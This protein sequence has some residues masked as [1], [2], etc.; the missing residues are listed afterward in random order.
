MQDPDCD[1]YV[2]VSKDFAINEV[3]SLDKVI[4]R[5]EGLDTCYMGDAVNTLLEHHH[6]KF[7]V[8]RDAKL[9]VWCQVKRS[10]QIKPNETL[11][12][13]KKNPQG[14][15][16][17]KNVDLLPALN[18]TAELVHALIQLQA[19]WYCY[20]GTYHSVQSLRENRE[21]IAGKVNQNGQIE[22]YYKGPFVQK[23]LQLFFDHADKFIM[24]QQV[25]H[26]ARY[27]IPAGSRLLIDPNV[28][29]FSWDSFL[30]DETDSFEMNY[31]K[32]QTLGPICFIGVPNGKIKE[33]PGYRKT[34]FGFGN[35]LAIAE[36]D[37]HYYPGHCWETN[38]GIGLLGKERWNDSFM[39]VLEKHGHV[40]THGATSAGALRCPFSGQ[41]ILHWDHYNHKLKLGKQWR[42]GREASNGAHCFGYY[43]K[44][45]VNPS[46]THY[47]HVC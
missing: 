23:N 28:H 31:F 2:R 1:C 16:T 13:P 26:S 15:V 14:L 29:F 44:E 30:D 43:G 7:K 25:E 17:V 4:V 34:G 18:T 22:A 5:F 38:A 37:G 3:G 32:I 41:K 19:T 36:I 35:G 42:F 45:V 47:C 40:L 6:G 33:V 39:L 20:E 21:Y 8:P 46:L 12:I 9:T 27:S 11:F 10:Y 24:F